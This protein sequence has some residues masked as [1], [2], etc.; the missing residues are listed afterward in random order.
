MAVSRRKFISGSGLVAASVAAFPHIARPADAAAT[1]SGQKPSKIIHLVADGMSL[2]TLSMAD[3]LA[4]L[5]RKRGL[6]WLDLHRRAGAHHGLMDM[7]S[8]SSL[9]T[10][11][12]AASSSW[13][14]GSRIVNGTVNILP[15]GRELT[16]LYELFGQAGWKRGLVT[17]T[18]ITHAT[19]AGFATKG[20]KREAA[21]SI[22]TQYLDRGV[23][24]L[25]GG[26]RKFFDKTKRKDKR[27]VYTEYRVKDYALLNESADLAAAPLDK[28]WLGTFA[29]SHL[30]FTVDHT[31]D[32]KLAK[33][34]PTL[35]A[36]TQRALEKLAR[37][38]RFI[39]QVEGGRVDHGCHMND[40]AAAFFDQIAFD[41]ALEVCLEFQRQ[42]ADTLLVITTDH[43][44]GNPGLNGTGLRYGL[45][46]LLFSNLLEV[47][48]SFSEIL[49]KLS[50]PEERDKKPEP[51]T[52]PA[53]IAAIIK[54]AIGYEITPRRAKLLVP[55][56]KKE[57][58]PIYNLMNTL[59]CQLGQL[60]ANYTGVGWTSGAHT[61]DYVPI[62]AIGPGAERF[63]GFIQN[64]DVFRH[65]TNL[66]GI[67]FRN[68]ESP[69]VG[70]V[71]P[72]SG[73][74][75]PHWMA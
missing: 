29:A 30:P 16:T 55:F 4:H 13:G 26:G 38:E 18:E 58:E 27:D 67:D 63:A 68:P 74:L 41:E 12:S 70:A 56:I 61:S 50:P 51:V 45:S 28:R 23:E 8:L 75:S 37:H 15:D 9:V 7:R 3:Q 71:S 65:Y 22:A 20:L 40:A 42:H 39:L 44:T 31:H 66:A 59:T 10:D 47:K 49:K 43:S 32:T 64:T 21:E 60:M 33:S 11:S 48:A 19:P 17:T 54:E 73:I 62:S 57:G 53:K 25:L 2:A 6:A 36:M 52:D 1:R 69:L 35:A 72:D 14:S 46:P 34:I 24:V 5:S